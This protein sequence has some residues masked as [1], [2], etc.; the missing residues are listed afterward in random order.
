MYTHSLMWYGMFGSALLPQPYLEQLPGAVTWNGLLGSGV[1]RGENQLFSTSNWLIMTA[2][3]KHF[4]T[5]SLQRHGLE[6]SC[7]RMHL[8]NI[9]GVL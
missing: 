9:H 7:R 6:I 4:L 8:M 1:M 5:R 2:A 3:I